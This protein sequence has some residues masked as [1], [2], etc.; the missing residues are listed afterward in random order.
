MIY[1]PTYKSLSTVVVK[2]EESNCVINR[3]F[4]PA[5][6]RKSCNSESTKTTNKIT[7][8][9]MRINLMSK[10][11]LVPLFETRVLLY[12]YLNE[13]GFFICLITFVLSK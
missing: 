11:F 2:Q 5:V 9:Q 4:V 12:A 7:R 10:D 8:N 13:G 6:G 1:V 3:L